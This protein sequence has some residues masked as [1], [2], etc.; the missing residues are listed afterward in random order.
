MQLFY[1]KDI[2]SSLSL[3]HNESKHCMRV[4]RK[5]IN[6]FIF[7]TDGKGGFYKC[8]IEGFEKKIV[9][10]KIIEKKIKKKKKYIQLAIAFPKNRNRIEWMLEKITELGVNEIFPIICD[11][12]ER[13]KINFDRCEKILISS[14]KQSLGTFL[15][16]IH[17]IQTF[18]KF[19]QSNNCTIKYIAHCNENY[20]RK[21]IHEENEKNICVMI[22]PEGDFSK[23]EINIAEKMNFKALKLSENRLRTETAAIVA[24]YKLMVL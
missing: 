16:K 12:S 2:L 17:N 3:D 15:P 8:K 11:N 4:L 24:C 9:K 20:K 22:G 10:L 14:M 5:N 23:K 6:D 21:I 7:I 1:S 18:N 13:K 19:V